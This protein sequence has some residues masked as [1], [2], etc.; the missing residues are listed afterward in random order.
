M[1]NFSTDFSVYVTIINKVTNEL[2]LI[3]QENN[4]GTYNPTILPISILSQNQIFFSLQGSIIR[5]SQ[6][7]VT[8]EVVGKEQQ[9][10]TFGFKCPLFSDNTLSIPLNQTDFNVSYY[11][12]NQPIQWSP[13]RANWGPANNFSHRGHPLYA[14][15]VIDE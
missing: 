10:I 12:T 4:S 2:R 6:G 15:L 8:Y 7:S 9:H 3:S 14:L 11:G 1:T 5:G 13:N